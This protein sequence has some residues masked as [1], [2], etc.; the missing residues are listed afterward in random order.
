MS[1]N[2]GHQRAYYLSPGWYMI[3]EIH[4]DYKEQK[5]SWEADSPLTS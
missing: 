1:Q 2:C 5:L 4:G 3:M